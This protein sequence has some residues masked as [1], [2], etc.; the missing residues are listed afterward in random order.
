MT[1]NLSKRSRI[2]REVLRYVNN[3]DWEDYGDFLIFGAAAF[4]CL[5]QHQK[6]GNDVLAGEEASDELSSYVLHHLG[7]LHANERTSLDPSPSVEINKIAEILGKFSVE[8]RQK[9][10][11]ELA[12]RVSDT[13][14]GD[15]RIGSL[16]GDA[17]DAL[18]AHYSNEI[19]SK[20]DQMV[21]RAIALDP[22]EITN[23]PD[24][25]IKSYF[26]EVH[27]CFLY[28]FRIACAVLCRALLESALGETLDP[29]GEINRM[30]K[31]N[32]PQGRD[33]SYVLHLLDKAKA[34]TILDDSQVRKGEQ[35][36]EAGDAAIHR[37]KDF[38]KYDNDT[39][40]WEIVGDTRTILEDLYKAAVQ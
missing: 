1:M 35:I 21:V 22:M 6:E 27:R 9:I 26:S 2:L 4:S 33:R 29:T 24:P 38:E 36:K 30:R 32:G 39:K 23:S 7:T 15:P 16:E 19:L 8:S 28:G 12:K 14:H 5:G 13:G 25:R 11:K 40:L 34:R 10:H 37:L 31:Q 18:D 3:D 20:L 17:E